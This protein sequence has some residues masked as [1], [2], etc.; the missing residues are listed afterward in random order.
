MLFTPLRLAHILALWAR[1]RKGLKLCGALRRPMLCIAAKLC[2][3]LGRFWQRMSPERLQNVFCHMSDT[4][5]IESRKLQAQP[6]NA[7][8]ALYQD[9]IAV[10]ASRIPPNLD[11][12]AFWNHDER[13]DFWSPSQ[14][15]PP[16]RSTTH[17]P[18][19]I[20]GL[21]VNQI[22]RLNS[23]SAPDITVIPE[24]SL[25]TWNDYPNGSHAAH[26]PVDSLHPHRA[27]QAYDNPHG[28]I[29]VPVPIPAVAITH[30]NDNGGP[31]DHPVYLGTGTSG[32]R[33]SSMSSIGAATAVEMH[34]SSDYELGYVGRDATPNDEDGHIQAPAQALL[35]P[36]RSPSRNSHMTSQNENRAASRL[37]SWLGSDLSIRHTTSPPPSRPD[38]AI[39]FTTQGRTSIAA[40]GITQEPRCHACD[41]DELRPYGIKPITTENILRYQRNIIV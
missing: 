4:V 38:S 37:G 29:S 34:V 35:G 15:P 26:N 11:L 14:S 5:D 12:E 22:S 40:S 32:G 28:Y 21:A 1:L 36:S 25:S 41:Q 24:T 8:Y 10:S 19:S 30:A 2:A 18:L 17:I 9:K 23:R 3:R 7:H 27:I 20:G 39:S 31:D 16:S 33:F 6:P 13:Q